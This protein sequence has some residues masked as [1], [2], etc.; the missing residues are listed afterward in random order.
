MPQ[1]SN[2]LNAGSYRCV[3]TSVLGVDITMSSICLAI[4][5]RSASA[6]MVFID[7]DLITQLPHQALRPAHPDPVP[8][9]LESGCVRIVGQ[10]FFDFASGQIELV[11]ADVKRSEERRVG[12]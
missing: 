7:Q 11:S 10:D 3:W 4:G 2:S 8:L 5:T 12:K 6:S 9:A 1:S